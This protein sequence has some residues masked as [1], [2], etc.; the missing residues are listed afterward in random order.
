MKKII[1]NFLLFFNLKIESTVN[2][3]K[4]IKNLLIKRFKAKNN[5]TIN[6]LK[7]SYV[8]IQKLDAF[9]ISFKLLE[10][11]TSSLIVLINDFKVEV[12]SA[13]DIFILSEVFVDKDYNFIDKEEYVFLDIGLNIGISSLFFSAKK[14]IKHIYGFEPVKHTF[15]IAKR[16]VKRN[17][18]KNISLK[19]IGLGG[20]TRSEKFIFNSNFKGNS[21]LRGEDSYSIN[22]LNENERTIV[23]VEIVDIKLELEE[24]INNNKSCKIG[25]KIDCEGAEYE[26]L[27]RLHTAS[28]LAKVDVLLI[29]WHDKGAND[30]ENILK[31]N[32]F[33]IFSRVLEIN[34]GI[35]YATR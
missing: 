13:E 16:N 24:I 14:N 35:I 12:E 21:G 5:F 6:L 19:N 2:K 20:S 27:Q 7:Q 4:F 9:N 22:R 18:I 1:K 28:L 26:I 11:N 15:N 10:E 8:H 33:K 3:N 31:V 25:L 30:L 17:N 23:D 32:N 34:S 29:E